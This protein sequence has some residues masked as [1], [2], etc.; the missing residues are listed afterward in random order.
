MSESHGSWTNSPTVYA[1]QWEDCDSTGAGCVTIAGATGQTYTLAASDVGD[2]IRVLETT[3]NAGASSQ[4]A[5]SAVTGVVQS[6][7]SVPVVQPPSGGGSPGGQTPAP[8]HASAV[9]GRVA[10]AAQRAT[11]PISCRGSPGSTCTLK[12]ALTVAE[13]VQGGK[14][15]AINASGKAKKRSVVLGTAT[16]TLLAGQSRTITVALNRAGKRLVAKWHRLRIKLTIDS[17]AGARTTVIA[18]RTITFKAKP[19]R[20][21]HH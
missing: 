9:V 8:G 10:V 20:K 18:A 21:H 13:T 11:V 3:S 1:Y 14:V 19:R 16:A 12:L 4:P 7:P 17:P 15:I 2:T 6:I 5:S